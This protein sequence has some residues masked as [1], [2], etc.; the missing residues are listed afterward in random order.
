MGNQMAGVIEAYLKMRPNFDRLVN[1]GKYIFEHSDSKHEAKIVGITG[2]SKGPDSLRE[3]IDRKKYSDPLSEI[4]DLA[5]IR[6]VCSYES[7]LKHIG[8]FVERTFEVKEHIDQSNVLGVDR[9]GYHG[10]H[11]IVSLGKTYSGVRYQGIVGLPLEIQVRT[12][13]QDAWALTSHQLVYKDEA[14]IPSSLRRD[15]NNVASLLEIAQG[16]FDNVRDKRDAYLKEIERKQSVEQDFLNQPVDYD[17]L[18][19][20]TSWK[21]PDLGVDLSWHGEL[22]RDLDHLEFDT[23]KK[24]DLA[25]E[26]AKPAVLAYKKNYPELFSTGTDHITKSLGFVSESFRIVHSWGRETRHALHS[27]K[28]LVEPL[29]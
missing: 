13:L 26:S 14:M 20:Y 21:Y 11:Y 17:T 8:K 12:V 3:K 15:L 2:R 6:I 24:I 9:M 10:E 19:A 22:L 29:N 16:V 1:E 5:G 28:H 25:V 18:L 7:D 4:D 23:L 27:L